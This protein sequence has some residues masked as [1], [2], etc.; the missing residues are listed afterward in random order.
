MRKQM[1]G[2]TMANT[3]VTAGRGRLAVVA[4]G[5]GL[6]ALLG[7]W[8]WG[9]ANPDRLLERSYARVTPQ[10]TLFLD[11]A[12]I[13]GPSSLPITRVTVSVT[14]PTQPQVLMVD[15]EPVSSGILA[16]PLASGDRVQ[17]R[18]A[19]A[20]A[21]MIEVQEAADLG[22]PVVG[23]PGVRLQFVTARALD[24]RDHETLRLIF[25]IRDADQ[26]KV[27]PAAS[28]TAGKVL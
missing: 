12:G 18:G 3:N 19:N 8:F 13:D 26:A 28:V 25:A 15:G 9:F 4:A 10:G 7:I 5:S 2:V 11:D 27:V 21:R 14:A 6:T 17:I 20:E 23:L 24:D 22:A 1:R 16:E